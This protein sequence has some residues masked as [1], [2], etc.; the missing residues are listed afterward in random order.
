MRHAREGG[1]WRP[2][3]FGSAIVEAAQKRSHAIGVPGGYANVLEDDHALTVQDVGG[4][5]G[6][7]GHVRR[8]SA[9]QVDG[10]ID[11]VLAEEFPNVRLVIPGGQQEGDV[12][13]SE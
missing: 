4:R 3:G 2:G 6:D 1:F 5:D 8:A 11:G 12:L 13:V 9:R 7:G 10:Q